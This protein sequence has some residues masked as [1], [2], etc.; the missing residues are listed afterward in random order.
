[1]TYANPSRVANDLANAHDAMF[2][3]GHGLLLALVHELRVGAV[4]D[5]LQDVVVAGGAFQDR[6]FGLHGVVGT[7][8]KKGFGEIFKVDLA[9]ATSYLN[10]KV[11][12]S[13]F[14]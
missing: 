1:M 14:K 3:A 13:T 10:Q 7:D 8:D 11:W 12:L 9:T 4:F 2:G 5:G 6:V